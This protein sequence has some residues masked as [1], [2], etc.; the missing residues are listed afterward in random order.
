M[1]T[2]LWLAVF[3]FLA[4]AALSA[5]QPDASHDTQFPSFRTGTNYV[6][7]DMYA[8][9]AGR[10][11]E[12]LKAEEI[13]LRE[14]G[15]PQK[16]DAFEH[17][18]VST[19]TPEAT[20]IEPNTVDD[21]RQ[22]AADSRARLFVIFLDTYN[23][24]FEGSAPM[25]QPLMRFLDRVLG[26]DDLVAVM[27]PEMSAA[28]V[29][30]A[31][32][33]TVISKMLQGNSDWGTKGRLTAMDDTEALYELCYPP[34]IVSEMKARRREK[35]TL[36]ALDDLVTV[37]GGVREE[38]KAV[39]T[40]SEGWMQYGEN[41]A[42]ANGAT[43]ATT[44]PTPPGIFGRIPRATG[45]VQS[46]RGAGATAAKCQADLLALSRMDDRDRLVQLAQRAN[47]RNVTFYTVYPRGL[48]V[49][50]SS[51]GSGPT[52]RPQQDEANLF[53]KQNGLRLIAD[54]TDGL[55]IV[56]T[57]QVNAAVDRIV[58]DLS[59]YYLLG[60]YSTNAKLDGKFRSISVTVRRPNVRV[61]ARRGYRALTTKE[62]LVPT[63]TPRGE[64]AS[65]A[66]GPM[67]LAGV[68]VDP[69]APFLLRTS[70]WMAPAPGSAPAGEF[71][72]VGELE[73]A[74]RRGTAWRGGA[75]AAVAVVAPDGRT[76]ISKTLDVSEAAGTFAL[77]VPEAGNVG[78]GEYMVRVRLTPQAQSGL[79]I[80]DLTRVTV[81][82]KAS[83]IGEPV[84]WR[85]GPTTGAK[86]VVTADP[87]F[88]R[89]EW[90]RLEF[91]TETTIPAVATL[92]DRRGNTTSVPVQVTERT[93]PGGDIR[94]IVAEVNLA[95]LAAGDYGIEL[96][97]GGT[98]HVTEFRVVP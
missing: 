92:L 23:T 97:V 2:R 17:I 16:I 79:P 58:A 95:P 84:M 73:R 96:T 80:N 30:F 14:D 88:I 26:P 83:P 60:Y 12:D 98:R 81:P 82:E 33:T 49:S 87:R 10:P 53:T 34:P 65:P 35:L 39:L 75:Q 50:D 8:T 4:A 43:S 11:I 41:P 69:H 22:I 90:L 94:W 76:V 89:S 56:N 91:P 42:L 6:R 66:A 64:S 46:D 28:D 19:G 77:R 67:P 7:V 9:G 78:P 57:N 51:V 61:R 37:L 40:I 68:V 5:Q 32:K 59:S 38:R 93:N 54:S 13:D 21:S 20:R 55:A 47:R 27:T 71:W 1:R 44:S 74:T 45:E 85:R 52:P 48:V 72:I 62:V 63:I 15:V 3:A 24:S 18:K 25:R 86:Y 36:D 29:T 31:R 70:S